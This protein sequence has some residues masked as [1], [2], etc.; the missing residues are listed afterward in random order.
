[1]ENVVVKYL[2][3]VVACYIVKFLATRFILEFQFIKKFNY[4]R[5]ILPGVRNWNNRLQMI[6]YFELFSFI[7]SLLVALYFMVFSYFIPLGSHIKL[8]ISFLFYAFLVIA[9]KVRF[10]VILTNYP[11]SLLIMDTA[12]FLA[13]SL[14]QFIVMAFMNATL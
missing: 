6:Y 12:I 14:L 9:D 3:F 8:I 1:M 11:Y 2:E 10:S 7:Q 13:V 4:T 5:E